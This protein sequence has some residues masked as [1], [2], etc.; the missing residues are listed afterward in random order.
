MMPKSVRVA[1]LS[2][3][4]ASPAAAQEGPPVVDVHLHAPMGPAPIG[5]YEQRLE[6]RLGQAQLGPDRGQGG[7]RRRELLTLL[8]YL[9]RRGLAAPVAQ[10]DELGELL[11]HADLALDHLD[12][13]RRGHRST[14]R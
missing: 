5:D 7:A 12:L 14:T 4:F 2:M 11:A 3:L 13:A 1:V 9:E 8:E 10:L 6:A